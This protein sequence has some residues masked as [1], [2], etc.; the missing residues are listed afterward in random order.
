MKIDAIKGLVLISAGSALLTGCTNGRPGGH[1]PPPPPPVISC[2]NEDGLTATVLNHTDNFVVCVYKGNTTTSSNPAPPYF[3]LMVSEFQGDSSINSTDKFSFFGKLISPAH[4]SVTAAVVTS[5]IEGGNAKNPPE[6]PVF[7]Q[8]LSSDGKSA[9]PLLPLG[10]DLLL[11]PYS[12]REFGENLT[13]TLS[14]KYSDTV[15]DK[16]VSAAFSAAKT[17]LKS[18]PIASTIVSTTT[19]LIGS[20]NATGQTSSTDSSDKS[21]S[22]GSSTNA[23]SSDTK[24]IDD[25]VSS[26]FSAPGQTSSIAINYSERDYAD[27]DHLEAIG[28]DR[29]LSNEGKKV[30]ATIWIKP[31]TAMYTVFSNNADSQ[32]HLNYGS[33]TPAISQETLNSLGNKNIVDFYVA[34]HRDLEIGLMRGQMDTFDQVC[35]DGPGQFTQ[36][37]LDAST[38]AYVATWLILVSQPVTQPGTQPPVLCQA[39]LNTMKSLGLNITALAFQNLRPEDQQVNEDK[40]NIKTNQVAHFIASPSDQLQTLMAPRVIVS[41]KELVLPGISLNTPAYVD[42]AALTSAINAKGQGR[43]SNYTHSSLAS[44]IVKATLTLSGKSYPVVIKWSG[45]SD[46]DLIISMDIGKPIAGAKPKRVAAVTH[47]SVAQHG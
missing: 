1:A 28:Y 2:K 29:D 38:D 13:L 43:L 35:A 27:I 37:G 10:N 12:Q 18:N 40:S 21:S 41:Q 42:A 44:P 5:K 17:L 20:S 26:L 6:V 25:Y 7:S 8:S 46:D 16:F 15:S 34:Q 32:G 30:V 45:V 4:S 22:S 47:Q 14:Y 19:S 3:G 31:A 33:F 39:T 36:M 9:A 11:M 23:G 24:S